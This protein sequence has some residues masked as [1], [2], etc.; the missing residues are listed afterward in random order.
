M[1][2]ADDIGP[3]SKRQAVNG[4]SKHSK[5]DS[6]MKEE[7]WIEV[8]CHLP[9]RPDIPRLHVFASIVTAKHVSIAHCCHLW[10][11]NAVMTARHFRFL[12]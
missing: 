1:S 10:H 2:G 12:S 4:S 9:L 3:P 6:D 11:D 5:D 8:C 7:A